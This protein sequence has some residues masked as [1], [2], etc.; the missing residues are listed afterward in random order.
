[1][2]IFCRSDWSQEQRSGVIFLRLSQ[3]LLIL[4]LTLSFFACATPIGVNK[5]EMREAYRNINAN[6]LTADLISSDTKI[7]L[8]RYDLLDRFEKDTAVVISLLH[9][10]ARKDTRRDILFALAELS[11]FHGE[12]LKKTPSPGD[13]GL[14]PDY[15]LMSAIYAHHYLLGRAGED[16]PGP[17]DRRFL[18][19]SDLYNRALGQGLAT[20]KD[21]QLEFKDGVRHLPVGNITISFN[22]ES[23]GLPMEEFQSFLQADDYAVRGLTIRNRTTGL[24]SPLIAIKKK[25]ERLPRGQAMPVTAF[26]KVEGDISALSGNAAGASLELYSVYE[27][28]ETMVKGQ[29]IP[30]ETDSTTPIAYQLND[31]PVW[32]LGIKAFL[33]PGKQKSE[34]IMIQ[35]YQRGRIPLVFVHGTASSPVWWGE[36]WNTL[37]ADPILRKRFQFWFFFYN[38]SQPVVSSA[39]DLRSIL[40]D[41][42]A[43]IDP[44]GHD[45]ALRQMIVVG[46]SQGGL[47]TKLSVVKSGDALWRSIS[48]KS[49]EDLDTPPEMKLLLR[50]WA[51]IEPL[52]FVKRVVYISTPFRGSFQ[53]KGW[54]RS[55]IQRIVSIPIG[56]LALPYNVVAGNPNIVS[57]LFRQLKLPLEVSNKLPSSVDGMSPLNPLL[58]TLATMP[59]APGVK[60]HSII[61]IDGDDEPPNGNDGVVEY[62]S[63]RQ[64]GVE[65]EYIVRSGHSCQGHPLTIEEVRRILLEH[66][67]SIPPVPSAA[68][69]SAVKPDSLGLRAADRKNMAESGDFQKLIW[70]L[71]TE[72]ASK[73][74]P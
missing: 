5:M 67:K 35:P 36:M 26:L 43:K 69:S 33:T 24:G 8:K 50:K 30:L 37:S 20:G 52:P 48:D 31:A 62:K 29:K 44:Q 73:G 54:V 3:V 17:Y 22:K 55:I 12:R 61:A 53:A 16:A 2:K 57:D 13:L 47:L 27:E 23:L 70:D 64:E 19:A 25:T 51:I 59:V 28:S 32:D 66:L 46:H 15:F 10:K 58:Q 34:L 7:V 63:A 39:S 41:T 40:S 38:S 14:V 72:S 21:G 60:T 49:I 1:M 74:F 6:A 65:S 56:I 45:P 42:V 18:I 11:F 71:D 9:E 68:S 4:I